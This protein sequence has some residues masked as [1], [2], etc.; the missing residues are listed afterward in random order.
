MY[1]YAL[2]AGLLMA[3]P[4]LM[5]AQRAQAQSD[6]VE[7]QIRG[8]LRAFFACHLEHPE[9]G[10]PVSLRACRRSCWSAGVVPGTPRAWPRR[11][12]PRPSSSTRPPG[13]KH[14]RASPSARIDDAS[15]RIEIG[16]WAEDLRFHVAAGILAASMSSECST[17]K[18]D[19]A[20][21]TPISS[22]AR[23]AH[24]SKANRELA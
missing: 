2:V 9:L 11:L 23:R 4:R 20:S 8:V 24:Q 7:S 14:A 18:S 5:T 10:R 16:D 6:S 17:S 1:R 22:M 12:G 15:I 13:R 19:G 21:S 3:L